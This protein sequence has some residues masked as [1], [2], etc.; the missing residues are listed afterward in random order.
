MKEV[1]DVLSLSKGAA[2]SLRCPE[3][4]EGSRGA[5]LSLPKG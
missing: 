5:A 4:V 1:C 2:L 3:L